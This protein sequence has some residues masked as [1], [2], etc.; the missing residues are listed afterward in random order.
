MQVDVAVIE[1]GLGGRLDCTNIIHPDL[2]II[3][4]ISTDHTQLLGKSPEKIAWEK[5]GII[6]PHTPVI[7]GESTSLTRP[8]FQEKA[9]AVCAPIL[10]A[11]EQ[12]FIKK[13]TPA[14]C[15]KGGWIYETDTYGD[16]YGELGGLYQHKNTNTLL[17]GLQELQKVGYILPE[18]AV[19]N[20]FS[21]V[22]ELTGLMGRWQKLHE[23]PTLIC[24]TGHNVG[25]FTYITE[26]LQKLPYRQLHIV[27]GMVEDKEIADVLHLLP[28][29]A[30]YY[31]TR[32]D[33]Q[34]ALPAEILRDKAQHTGLQGQSYPD[35]FHAVKSAMENSLPED[36]IFVGGSTFVVADLL[37][38]RDALDLH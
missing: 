33:I 13:I 1:V 26:Q 37:T 7:I 35:V 25:G 14:H 8:I 6:K 28:E 22:C 15:E 3:T 17:H 29:N 10:F 24:D 38:H 5:A 30:I 2:C 20:G 23:R 18:N 16:L 4:N 21:Q 12:P 27:L 19:R 36:L 32:A 11:E 9:R 31:F 34:R